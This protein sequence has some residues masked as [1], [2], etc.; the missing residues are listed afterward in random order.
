MTPGH[1]SAPGPFIAEGRTAKILAYGEDRIVKLLRPGFSEEM[2]RYEAEKTQAAVIAGAP[3]PQVHGEIE[4]GGRPGVVFDRVDGPSL[5]DEIV[6]APFR[7][8][9]WGSVLARAHQR[10][11]DSRS[12][13]LPDVKVFL[14]SKIKRADALTPAQRRRLIELLEDLPDGDQ[15]LHGDLH[16]LNVFLTDSGPIVIDWVDAARGSP[17]ADIARSLWLIS[18]H[19]IPPDF[20]RRALM[21]RLARGLRIAYRRSILR[22]MDLSYEQVRRWRLPVLAG[23]L[24][25]GIEH[26]AKALLTRVNR[27]IEAT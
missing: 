20:L 23:R 21:A 6:R 2:L 24:S 5:L 8:V 13:Q 10:V 15:V 27:S 7:F 4:V 25:E 11:L 18:P 16:P 3:A 12:D 22:A 9:H 19:A 26:E 17:A 1:Q 14:A